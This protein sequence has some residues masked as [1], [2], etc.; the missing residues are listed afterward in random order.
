MYSIIIAMLVSLAVFFGFWQFD[1]SNVWWSI[2]WG[3]FAFGATMFGINWIVRKKIMRIMTEMQ[4][5]MTNGQKQLQTKINKFQSR[6]TGDP[7]RLMDETEKLQKK[8]LTDA[9]EFTNNLEP[10]CKWTPLFGRQLNTTRMQ[11]NYQMKD[12]KKVDELL[13]RSL[14]LDP[15]SAAM[16]LAR[17]YSNKAD[18]DE[19]EKTFQKS[20]ARLKYNQSALLYA[21]M[22][23]IYV[24]K[25]MTDKA[26]TLL[27]K[28]CKANENETLKRNLDRLANNKV[29]EFSNANF[30]DEWYALFLEP[31][32]IQYRRQQ[33][34][35]DGR[36]F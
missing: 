21:L 7:K 28:G 24:K 20:A 27:I 9:L 32:K 6:P 8:V 23:W 19:I 35:M 16:K 10:F 26:H 13:P 15:M 29:R 12:F 34:R 4:D 31:P 3:V 17:L 14:I 1:V 5:I 22:S 30:G 25:D 36:P 33:P 2:L 18:M 11:F